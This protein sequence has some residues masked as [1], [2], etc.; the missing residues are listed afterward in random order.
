[1][2]SYVLYT[3]VGNLCVEILLSK[4]FSVRFNVFSYYLSTGIYVVSPVEA[5]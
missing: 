5:Y 3:R 2:C 4:L 1:M